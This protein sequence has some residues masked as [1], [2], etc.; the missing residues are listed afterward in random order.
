VTSAWSSSLK[1]KAQYNWNAIASTFC[2]MNVCV[3]GSKMVALDA[4]SA[5]KRSTSL[6]RIR[7]K[8]L[9]KFSPEI[10]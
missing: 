8:N 9:G 1:A 6:P 7:V 5:T 4:L 10:Y 2:T 3:S